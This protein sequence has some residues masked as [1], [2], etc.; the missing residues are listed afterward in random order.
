MRYFY[1]GKEA[2]GRKEIQGSVLAEKKENREMENVAV[3]AK[4]YIRDKDLVIEEDTIYE[5]DRMC[6]YHRFG[7]K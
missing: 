3:E 4:K 2:Q 1:Y 7:K 5:V 6:M